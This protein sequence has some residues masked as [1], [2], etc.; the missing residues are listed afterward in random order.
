M[1]RIS[2]IL[3]VT[4]ALFAQPIRAQRSFNNPGSLQL[5]EASVP[6]LQLALQAR[7]I[8]SE[9]LVQMYLNRIAAYDKVG[10]N[11][12][13]S[14]TST[15]TRSKKH[16]LEISIGIVASLMDHSSEFRCC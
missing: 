9:Q 13:R 6:E 8:T 16:A 12:I 3:L 2:L 5:V 7:L 10:P 14:F 11:S 15:Q 4:I 1:K